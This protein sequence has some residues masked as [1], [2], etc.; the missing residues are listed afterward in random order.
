MKS[1]LGHQVTVSANFSFLRAVRGAGARGRAG[2]DPGR[3]R[4]ARLDDALDVE[5]EVVALLELRAVVDELSGDRVG[6]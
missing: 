4:S 3:A 5:L 6:P 2:R 1:L